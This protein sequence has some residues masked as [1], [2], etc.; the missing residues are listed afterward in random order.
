MCKDDIVSYMLSSAYRLA[1]MR[2]KIARYRVAPSFALQTSNGRLHHASDG[3]D[4]LK[5][6]SL[7]LELL[8]QRFKFWKIPLSVVE[9][10]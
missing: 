6:T 1:L 2:A 4:N 8:L 10:G 7:L 5:L 9:Q 3:F